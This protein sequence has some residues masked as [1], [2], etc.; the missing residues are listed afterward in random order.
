VSNK[1]LL[2]SFGLR[3][4][5]KLAISLVIAALLPVI[6]AYWVGAS[7]VLRGLERGL[8][9]ETEKHLS[10]GLNLLLRDVERLGHEATRLS[11]R[12]TLAT[13]IEEGDSSLAD[14]LEYESQHL[15]SVL[16]QMTS[17]DGSIIGRRDAETGRERFAGMGVT[18]ESPSVRAGLTYERRV[19]IRQHGRQLLVRATA[20]IVNERFQLMGVVVLSV[21]LDGLFA[22][23]L[24]ASL[25]ADVFILAGGSATGVPMMSFLDRLGARLDMWQTGS[26]VI[27]EVAVGR[28]SFENRTVLGHDYAVGYAPIMDLDGQVAGIFGVAVDRA[29]VLEARRGA[30]RSLGL[31]AAGAFAFAIGLAGLLSRRIS[32]PL[33]NLHHGA[34]AIAR[35]DLEHEIDIAEGD[36]IGDLARA[37]SHM[38]TALKEN[39]R[40]LAARMRE[41]VALHDAGR[42][43]SSVIETDQVLRKV[44]DSVA[45]VLHLRV[46]A[47]WLIDSEAEPGS[48]GHKKLVLGAARAKREDTRTISD[49]AEVD[50]LVSPLQ[51]LAEDVAVSRGSLRVD[52][53]A[54]HPVHAECAIAAS[55][56][57]SVIASVLERKGSVVGVI[58]VGRGKSARPFSDADESLLSTFADQAA[59]A[60][61]NATL[62]ARVRKFNEE[63]EAKVLLR[64]TELQA[65]NNELG[66]AITELRE[67]QAQLTLSERLAGLGQLVAGV[68]HEINSPSAAIRGTADSL[69]ETI[70]R[71]TSRQTRLQDIVTDSGKARALVE[72]YE[73]VAP[74]LSEHRRVPPAVVRRQARELQSGL[75]KDGVL[76]DTA[77]A[78]AKVLA[79]LG[80]DAELLAELRPYLQVESEE[81]RFLVDYLSD[82]VYVHRSTRTIQDAIRRIQRIV[83][84]LKGYSH[85]DQDAARVEADVH[86]GI[87]NTLVI[88]EHQLSRG[89]KVRRSYAA[90]PGVPIFVDE[91]NQVWTNLIHNAA[92]ALGGK[93]EIDIESTVLNDGIAVRIID[94]GPGIPDEVM[95]RIFEPFF[96]TKAKGEGT[97]L[98]LGIVQQIVEKHDGRVRCE[99]TPGRTCFEVWLP[100]TARADGEDAVDVAGVDV[101]SPEVET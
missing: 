33:Q 69:A 94:N 2:S 66:K 32:R 96:T 99:S 44:V 76:E 3:L 49:Q 55:I 60:I 77:Q 46:C 5:H 92:Q 68:A 57:G 39:Q 88:L 91:L 53:M 85:L 84:S 93:G 78:V 82:Y 48:P 80:V 20:P 70:K 40:R 75:E 83:G 28:N 73:R 100:R 62:Y 24:K 36:E 45:R 25:G 90:L 35:G 8:Q 54:S 101:A 65:I 98:G 52:S 56:D 38:T 13:A 42:A 37:F 22:D 30:T 95:A 97:G 21:P 26:E 51:S 64:T 63:L 23:R 15:P 18:S 71:L 7:V 19:T 31:G 6:V 89:I 12:K 47:L 43:V 29:P 34:I 58:L 72:I 27:S 14:V 87:E 50:A 10:V 11:A 16:I 9:A 41:I 61:E 1:R 59:T 86:E 67:T 79:E 17:A 4:R 74:E 81:G